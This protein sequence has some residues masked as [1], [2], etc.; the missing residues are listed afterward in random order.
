MTVRKRGGGSEEDSFGVYSRHSYLCGRCRRRSC[1][2]RVSL[3]S[4]S[5]YVSAYC[6]SERAHSRSDHAYCR[7]YY[8]RYS[9]AQAVQKLKNNDPRRRT[10]TKVYYAGDFF[11]LSC[12]G[13]CQRAQLWAIASSSMRSSSSMRARK[14]A[15]LDVPKGHL[16]VKLVSPIKD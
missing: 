2:Y 1:S 3:G 9:A 6:G 16:T 7:I 11:M 12:R 14:R 5:C 4:R 8:I 15:M 13:D 10:L